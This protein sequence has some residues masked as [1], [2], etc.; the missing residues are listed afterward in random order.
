[1]RFSNSMLGIEVEDYAAIAQAVEAA[2]FHSVS[3]SDHIFYPQTL[4][5]RYP[6]TPDGKPQYDPEESWPDP[7]VMCGLM[8]SATTSLQ[9]MTSVYIAPLRNPFVTAKAV[10]TAAR[11]TNNRVI[12]GIGAGWMRE[13]FDAMEQQFERRGARTEEII[14]VLRTLWRGG[15]VEHHGTYYDFDPLTISP[16]PTEPVPIYIGG[17]SPHALR[18]AAR[19]GDGWMGM[20]LTVEQI[21]EIIPV[22]RRELEEA[23]RADEPFEIG[24]S[25]LIVPHPELVA[26]LEEIGLTTILTSA[27][28]AKGVMR[29]GREQ[30][31]ELVE[32]FGERFIAP[33]AGT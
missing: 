10:G 8:A 32:S 5:S 16:V 18:R 15:Y 24:C 3:L 20:Y 12:L 29:A 2:G 19:Y 9:F 14:E 17:S 7:W 11:V 31:I 30:A 27:W 28:I 23:G 21:R 6:Y 22:I 13:E 33:L 1:M 25:P 4:T 26:E